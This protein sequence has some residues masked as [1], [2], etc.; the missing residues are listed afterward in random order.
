MIVFTH[1]KCKKRRKK[2]EVTNQHTKKTK[3]RDAGQSAT[4]WKALQSQN[5][6]MHTWTEE[7]QERIKN[8]K[9]S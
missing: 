3:S 2:K 9:G 7:R 4:V 5:V 1:K 8:I 6:R